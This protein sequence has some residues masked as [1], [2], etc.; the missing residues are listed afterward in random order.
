[1]S[2]MAAQVWRDGRLRETGSF[3]PSRVAR[4]LSQPERRDRVREE[5]KG[6]GPSQEDCPCRENEYTLG[7]SERRMGKAAEAFL[8][9]LEERRDDLRF[10]ASL[11]MTISSREANPYCSSGAI[12]ARS[13]G[14]SGLATRRSASFRAPSSMPFTARRAARTASAPGGSFPVTFIPRNASS[15][16][17]FCPRRSRAS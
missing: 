2:V 17:L 8:S 1:A 4:A 15:A 6:L 7:R 9:P 13:S 5:I 12:S 3:E 14:K 16:S 11:R 10:F